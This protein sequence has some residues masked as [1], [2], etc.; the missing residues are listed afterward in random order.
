M[1]DEIENNL[2][3]DDSDNDKNNKKIVLGESDTFTLLSDGKGTNST[4]PSSDINNYQKTIEIQ[5]VEDKTVQVSAPPIE[6]GNY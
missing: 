4:V 3:D 5:T 6:I 1:F 2:E